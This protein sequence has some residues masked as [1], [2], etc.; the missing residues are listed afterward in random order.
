LPEGLRTPGY[1]AF[2][3]AIRALGGDARAILVAQCLLGA[4]LACLVPAIGTALGL[5]LRGAFVAGLL[6]ALHPVLILF[7]CL[8]LTEGLFNVCTVA[9]LYLATRPASGWNWF[10]AAGLIGLAG[11]VRQG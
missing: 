10:L 6:Y 9:A 8:V 11:L 1:P 5:S 3:A 2:L 7:D 4:L